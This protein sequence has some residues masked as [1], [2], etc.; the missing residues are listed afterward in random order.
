[1][2]Y[3]RNRTKAMEVR[4][5]S[6]PA[7]IIPNRRGIE[8]MNKSRLFPVHQARLIDNDAA[9]AIGV[10]LEKSFKGSDRFLGNHSDSRIS[11]RNEAKRK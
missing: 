6:F 2:A 3:L 9:D 11:G 10:P 4:G 7:T 5:R 1:M 8:P